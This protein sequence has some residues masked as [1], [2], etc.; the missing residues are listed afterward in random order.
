VE[1]H[2]C[3]PHATDCAFRYSVRAYML[4]ELGANDPIQSRCGAS[5]SSRQLPDGKSHHGHACSGVAGC[6]A[7]LRSTARLPSQFRQSLPAV[8]VVTHK[9]EA[10]V[11]VSP[12]SVG[13]E[14][15]DAAVSPSHPSPR[16][17]TPTRMKPS[18]AVSYTADTRHRALGGALLLSEGSSLSP[19]KRLH[20]QRSSRHAMVPLSDTSPHPGG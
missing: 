16:K 5:S 8:R 12:Q 11:R 17:S 2:R 4:H 13:M 6:G 20:H 7:Q 10:S 1:W 3:S 14:H 15:L 18:R 19:G 9:T